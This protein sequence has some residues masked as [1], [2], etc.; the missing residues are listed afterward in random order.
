M[1]GVARRQAYCQGCAIK[2]SWNVLEFGC[3]GGF[4]AYEAAQFVGS[5][6]RVCAIDLSDN[7]ISAARERCKEFGYVDFQVTNVLDTPFNE[8]QFDAAFGV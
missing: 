1:A 7:Q 8:N 3:G 4:Y 6:G 5:T 2:I